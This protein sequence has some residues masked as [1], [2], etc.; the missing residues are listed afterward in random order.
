MNKKMD[1]EKAL[2]NLKDA[3]EIIRDCGLSY[4]LID[5][6]LLG[7]VREGNF[8]GHDTDI[9]LGVF[10]EEWTIG[11]FTDV[12]YKMMKA[13]F[14]LYHSFGIFGKHFEVAWF[15]DGIK[16]DFFF[17]YKVGD[18]I[19][20][21][22]FLKGGRTLPDDILT[23]EYDAKNFTISNSMVFN[24]HIFFVPFAPEEVLETKYGPEWRTPVKRWD[25]A[26]G[27]KNLISQG[28]FL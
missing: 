5:G 10:M 3:T 16:I 8:I 18:K 13:G 24:G 20:F 7:A 21:N 6:T 23:Y 25:W 22:A 28:K 11:N 27:P 14:I 2:K 4:F 17:Y 15:R 26:H 9:D 1:T 12:F 19:R